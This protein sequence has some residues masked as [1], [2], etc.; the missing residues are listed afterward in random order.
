[1]AAT[2]LHCPMWGCPALVSSTKQ[3]AGMDKRDIC[4]E[5]L[6]PDI[7]VEKSEYVVMLYPFLEPSFCLEV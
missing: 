5:A 1:M 3:V 2:V 6:I 7:I 4:A